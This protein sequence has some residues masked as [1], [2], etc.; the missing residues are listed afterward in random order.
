MFNSICKC[1]GYFAGLNMEA[2]PSCSYSSSDD[3]LDMSKGASNNV[4]ILPVDN[5]MMTKVLSPPDDIITVKD[6]IKKRNELGSDSECVKYLADKLSYK[7][8]NFESLRRTIGFNLKKVKQM[9]KNKSKDIEPFL[10]SAFK[11]PKNELSKIEDPEISIAARKLSDQTKSVVLENRALKRNIEE[12]VNENNAL[13]KDVARMASKLNEAISVLKIASFEYSNLLEGKKEANLCLEIKKSKENYEKKSEEVN[14][15]SM[16]LQEAQKKLSK[17][18]TR[19]VN[20]RLKRKD[21]SI[22]VL[23]DQ[24]KSA[25]KENE[26]LKDKLEISESKKDD[27]QKDKLRLQ[28]QISKLKIQVKE[29]KE[30]DKIQQE[31]H[32]H[33][34]HEIKQNLSAKE[35]EIDQLRHVM[36]LLES[37]HIDTF[38]NGTY[39]N[40]VRE[41]CMTLITECNVSM[42][43]L[44]DVIRSVLKSFTG[45]IPERLPSKSLLSWMM[46]EAKVVASKHVGTEMLTNLDMA[47][48][49]GNVLHQD[50]TTKFHS[51]YEGAQVTLKSGKSL[52]IG[53]RQTAGGDGKTYINAFEDMINDLSECLGGEFDENKAKLIC[54]IKN[55]MSDQ[56]ATN[57]VFNDGVEKIRKT[58]L[59]AIVKEY[60]SMSDKEKEKMNEMGQFSCR[61]HLLGNFG[62]ES[63][64]A[65]GIFE[66]SVVE[67]KNPHAYGAESGSFRLLRTAAKAFTKRGSDK[68][69]VHSYFETYL[70]GKGIKNRMVTFHG[71]R[72]NVAFHDGAAVYHHRNEIKEF[73][74]CWPEK[75]GLLKCIAFDINE[76]VYLSGCRAMGI[77]DKLCTGPFWRILEEDDCI[78]DLNTALHQMQISLNQWSQDGKIP[79]A[80][81][82]IFDVKYIE[83]DDIYHSLFQVTDD[84]HLDALTIM[85][86]EL[87][88]SQLLILLER[89]AAS[90]LPEGKYWNPSEEMKHMAANVP[91]T[92]TLSE[93]DMATL[94]NLLRIKPASSS[95]SLEAFVMCS[96]NKP[97]QWLA[98]LPDSERQDILDSARKMAS[99]IKASFEKR[100]IQLREELKQKLEM[101]QKKVADKEIKDSTKKINLSRDIAQYGGPWT[102]NE[103]HEKMASMDNK[104]IRN[105]LLTQIK[106]HKSVLKSKGDKELFQESA[107]KRKYTNDELARNLG[108]ILDLN[109]ALEYDENEQE[110]LL[111]KDIDISRQKVNEKKSELVKTMLKARDKRKVDQQKTKLPHYLQKPEDLVGKRVSHKCL[112]NGNEMWFL[113]DVIGIKKVTENTLKTEYN[114]KYDDEPEETWFFPLLSDLKNG[115]LMIL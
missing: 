34:T 72:I 7:D 5:E 51:H 36:E 9:R 8:C 106:F 31:L 81:E 68:A 47:S 41:C 33:I 19:N 42:G 103:I 96:K 111:Y 85:A 65:L 79:L 50:A 99:K 55:F 52:T 101:K 75:N 112:E 67:G 43:K 18:N 30:K 14:E 46:A 37:E 69:G 39:T 45:K 66:K 89:Q 83:K 114:I 10:T 3:P 2:V 26:I 53:L 92:N 82:C 35:K 23:K 17:F 73:L 71:H 98:T 74:E 97:F 77:F 15:L 61:L 62:I 113:G 1:S 70:A 28:K 78:L 64:K 29:L 94:D 60:H 100:K 21:E 95:L 91:K 38:Y 40:E 87:L 57:G 115:D 56:C 16:K 48:G 76:M 22:A 58:L 49:Q 13:E 102:K 4:I 20:K 105:A 59:P 32:E 84:P 110:G 24:V 109:E 25:E 27:N 88:S 108:K 11:P 104:Q 90:Q 80:E 63:D 93:R 44:P 12:V 107:N 86:L 54:S 6:L